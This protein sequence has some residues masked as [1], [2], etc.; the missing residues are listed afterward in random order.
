MLVFNPWNSGEVF[1][2]QKMAISSPVPSL[3]FKGLS[4]DPR[5]I[6]SRVARF[7]QP[8][9]RLLLSKYCTCTIIV[10]HMATM[11]TTHPYNLQWSEV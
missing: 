5:N 7:H 11:I 8:N 3:K 9:D 10:V 2:V 1:M 4:K 6:T